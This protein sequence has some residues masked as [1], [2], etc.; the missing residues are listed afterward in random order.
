MHINFSVSLVL[1]QTRKSQDLGY[2]RPCRIQS[3]Q[4]T[5]KTQD[6][7]GKQQQQQEVTEVTD[8]APFLAVGYDFILGGERNQ[9]RGTSCRKPG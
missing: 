2:L 1:R 7:T 6:E 9:K 4:G 5:L 3:C 8:K